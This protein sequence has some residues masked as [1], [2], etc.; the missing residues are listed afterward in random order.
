[1]S[2]N[3]I[4]GN[5]RKPIPDGYTRIYVGRRTSYKPEYGE[6][7]SVLGNPYTMPK[8]TRE[9]AIDLYRVHILEAQCGPTE[10]SK[11]LWELAH[12]A[13]AGEQLVLMCWCAPLACHSEVV[14]RE[15]EDL[16]PWVQS[17]ATP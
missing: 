8:Y 9:A 10:E 2:G 14:K 11:A 5:V 3:V 1:M 4:V 17:E 16:I 6:D 12:R 15:I 13:A 7:F